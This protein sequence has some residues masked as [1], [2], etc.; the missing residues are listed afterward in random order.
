MSTTQNNDRNVWGEESHHNNMD[1]D[2]WLNDANFQQQSENES[3]QKDFGNTQ[4]QDDSFY[5]NSYGT[6]SDSSRSLLT[7]GNEMVFENDHEGQ[8]LDDEYDAAKRDN[9]QWNKSKPNLDS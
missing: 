1:S 8:H 6:G 5:E 2:R 4:N 7:T 9:D 3:R